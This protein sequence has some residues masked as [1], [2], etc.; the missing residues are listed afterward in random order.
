MYV[1]QASK[2][3]LDQ[4]PTAAML[5]LSLNT[6]P[7]LGHLAVHEH[8]Q[9]HGKKVVSEAYSTIVDMV[10]RLGIATGARDCV[11]ERAGL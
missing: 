9:P 4:E 10:A 7:P 2:V 11:V 5:S 3:T 6:T 1:R 8:V